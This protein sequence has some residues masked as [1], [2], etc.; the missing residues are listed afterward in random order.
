MFFKAETE[1][2]G[3]TFAENSWGDS[4]YKIYNTKLDYFDAKARCEADG[5]FLAFPRSEAE[6]MFFAGL[7]TDD[8][9]T[10]WFESKNFWIGINDIEQE[11]NFVSV[12]GRD[13][14]FTNWN[15]GE[16]NGVPYWPNGEPKLFFQE[17]DGVEMIFN[18]TSPTGRWNDLPVYEKRKFICSINTRGKIFISNKNL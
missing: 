12:D 9:V 10:S 11:G 17:E 1:I 7:M 14:L 4:F 6:N 16:P 8:G 18:D 3:Y 2:M 15:H 13:I 5:T